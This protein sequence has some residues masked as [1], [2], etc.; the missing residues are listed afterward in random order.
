MK[1]YFLISLLCTLSCAAFAQDSSPTPTPWPTPDSTNTVDASP[2]TDTSGLY[3][4]W[5]N[6]RPFLA[7]IRQILLWQCGLM[8]VMLSVHMFKEVR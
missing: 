6:G 1:R 7:D 8:L 3:D 4:Q 2:S 5:E